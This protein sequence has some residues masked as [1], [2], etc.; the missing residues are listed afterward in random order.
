MRLTHDERHFISHV[1]AFFAASDGIVNE[2]IVERFSNDVQV[3]EARSFYGFQIMIENVHSEIYSLLIDTYIKD[4]IEKD[5]LFD[6]IETIPCIKR[7]AEWSLRWVSDARSTFA[8][9][10][11]AFAA[12]KGIFFSSF[13]A[14]IFWVKKRGLMPGL[15]F[16]NQLISQDEGMHADFACLL[17]SHLRRRPHSQTILH[18]VS[19]AVEIEKELLTGTFTNYSSYSTLTWYLF[20]DALPVNLIG[21]NC[22]LMCQYIEFVADRLLMSLGND[23]Y[24]GSTNPFDFMDINS[25]QMKPNFV[26]KC[27]S[28][29]SKDNIHHSTTSH[30]KSNH[31]SNKMLY[32]TGPNECLQKC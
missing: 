18:I 22:K 20:L 12:I 14:A 25:L 29:Y 5:H 17:F 10:V 4:P 11:V 31:S 6:A 24:Y 1:L 23:K 21:M 27:A 7:K 19:E 9:R 15:T 8:E 16:S 2:N 30:S 32:V 28:D 26:K 3:A 13:F